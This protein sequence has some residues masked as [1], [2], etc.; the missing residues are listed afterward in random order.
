MAGYIVS[1]IIVIS[2]VSYADNARKKGRVGTTEKRQQNYCADRKS[3]RVEGE[4]LT[5]QDGRCLH[6]G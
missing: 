6:Q 3:I 4:M 2:L 5:H 1:L